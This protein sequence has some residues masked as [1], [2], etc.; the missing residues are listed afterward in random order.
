M[1]SI[2]FPVYAIKL[3][4]FVIAGAIAGLGGGLLANLNGLVSPSLFHWTHSGSLMIMVILGGVGR[5]LGGF[6]GA[7]LLLLAQELLSAYT[8]H[9]ALGVGIALL[10]VGLFPPAR[11]AAIWR[12]APR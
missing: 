9:W 6:A 10:A 12:R 4:A 11:P 5:F 1:E 7:A 3:V 8:T 2:G